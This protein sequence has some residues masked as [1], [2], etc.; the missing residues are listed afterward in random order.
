MVQI[1]KFKAKVIRVGTSEGVII[2]SHVRKHYEISKGDELSV[3]LKLESKK[4]KKEMIS[5]LTV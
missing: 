4:E 1:K 3:S 5:S 2:P